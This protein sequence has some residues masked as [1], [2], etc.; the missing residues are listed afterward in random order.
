VWLTA[1]TLEKRVVQ[2]G[3]DWIAPVAGR[4]YRKAEGVAPRS[5]YFFVPAG[6]GDFRI[7]FKSA[8]LRSA[9]HYGVRNAKGEIVADGQWRTG[10]NPRNDWDVAELDAGRPEEDEIWSFTCGYQSVGETYLR[11]T[12][13]PGYVASAPAD[14]FTPDPAL[15]H[16]APAADVPAGEEPVAY[17]ETDLPWGG[18][19]AYLRAPFVLRAPGGDK[20]MLNARQGTVEIW[21]KPIDPPT[22]LRNRVLLTCGSFHIMR[23]LNLGTYAFLGGVRFDRYFS[24]PNSR[25]THLAV[26]WKPS[27]NVNADVEV[28]IYADGIDT[29]PKTL[30]L[31]KNKVPEDW[32]GKELIAND[33][34]FVGGL[35]VS[36]TVRYEENFPRPEAHFEADE[37]TR[38]L[39]NFD[40]CGEAWLF[41]KKH[42]IR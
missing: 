11:F 24:L 4:Y 14:L 7:E 10:S 16:E 39:Y 12:G 17:V 6:T 13:V 27:E 25:W 35:R 9:I 15:R 22:H 32:P 19:A 41:G 1:S 30:E 36:D 20:P 2:T 31:L 42:A 8:I 21:V 28:R 33:G 5:M 29:G 38:V 26:T 3:E 18:R 23:R 37:H 40:G 34:I